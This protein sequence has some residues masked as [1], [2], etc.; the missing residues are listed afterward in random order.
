MVTTAA[1]LGVL[2]A[3]IATPYDADGAVDTGL[4]STLV[5][6]YVSRGVEGIYC[7]GSSGEGLLLSADER[8]AVVETAV[9]AAEGRIPVVAHVGALSTREAIDLGRR[10]QRAGA[11]ALSMIP[12]IYYSFGIEAVLDHYRA[13]LDA[14]DL[15]LI[16]YNI[17]QFTGTEFTLETAGELLGDDRVIGLKQT[18]HNMYAL[19]R[20]KAAFPDKAYIN[21]FDEV[22]VPA[23]AAGARGTI[24]TTVGLQVELFQ[25]A[26]RL[27][28]AGDLV[29]AQWVQ[30]RINH[31][32]AELVAIDVFP[33]AKYLSGRNAG[34][35]GTLGDCRRPFRPLS[36]AART[37]LDALGTTLDRFLAEG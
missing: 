1:D 7:C 20:M 23:L 4:L 11:S 29:G 9:R 18:A 3:A 27:L 19:E 13:V 12:P 24:G 15:P 30:S 35:A 25:A 34:G 28:D 5:E 36:D 26:R 10:A 17:P 37:R 21:G 6:D 33:A 31:V 16:V 14:V 8:T 2:M 32:I 22:F